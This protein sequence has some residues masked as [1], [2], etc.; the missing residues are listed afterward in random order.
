LPI[1]VKVGSAGKLKSLHQFMSLKQKKI[2]VRFD[3]NSPTVQNVHYKLTTTGKEVK[4]TLITLPHYF[5][6]RL[7]FLLDTL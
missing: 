1:E 2:A 7:P 6:E 4:F 3:K 5:V